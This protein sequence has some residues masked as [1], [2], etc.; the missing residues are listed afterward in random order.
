MTRE[1]RAVAKENG[2][3]TKCG[4]IHPDEGY[5]MCNECLLKV[6]ISRIKNASTRKQ[7]KNQR[8]RQKRYADKLKENGLCKTCRK[9]LDRSGMY[10][11]SCLEKARMK[12]RA[13]RQECR[14]NH[15]CTECHK[16]IVFG[17][18]KICF[19]C[20]A[21]MQYYR[22]PPSSESKEKFKAYSRNLYAERKAQGICTRCGK[23]K[24]APG[25]AKCFVCLEK[26]AR[27]KRE[28]YVAKGTNANKERIANGICLKCGINKADSPSKWCKECQEESSERLAKARSLS[29]FWEEDNRIVF[30]RWSNGNRNDNS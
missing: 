20:R 18:D 15:I 8:A 10:C 21:K 13:K 25:K 1:Q 24:A 26:D 12:D 7:D 16:N 19:E 3:C 9:P 28:K 6:K 30:K 22:K 17:S 5:V 2:L 14:E 4:K 23:R 11:S 27:S 29:H